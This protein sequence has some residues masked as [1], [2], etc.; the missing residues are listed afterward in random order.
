MHHCP[1]VAVARA[2]AFVLKYYG[3]ESVDDLRRINGNGGA[4]ERPMLQ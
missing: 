3:C 2:M 1:G 4:S